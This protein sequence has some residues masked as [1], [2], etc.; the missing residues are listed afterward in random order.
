M[1]KC[2]ISIFCL[3]I[4]QCCAREAK[5]AFSFPLPIDQGWHSTICSYHTK[6]HNG[7][8]SLL[9][10]GSNSLLADESIRLDWKLYRSPPSEIKA[11]IIEEARALNKKVKIRTLLHEGEN[12]AFETI[13]ETN[14]ETRYTLYYLGLILPFNV[15]ITYMKENPEDIYSLREKYLSYFRQ[16]KNSASSKGL[17]FSEE[18]VFFEGKPLEFTSDESNYTIPGESIIVSMPRSWNVDRIKGRESKLY[19]KDKC[20]LEGHSETLLFKL[21]GE[22]ENTKFQKSTTLWG[23]DGKIIKYEIK[24]IDK[25]LSQLTAEI[26]GIRSP[27]IF[28]FCGKKEDIEKEITMIERTLQHF[29]GAWAA[30]SLR[31]DTQ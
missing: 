28:D 17:S 25:S 12:I 3:F 27:Y 22:S 29:S 30:S 2:L 10:K 14:G 24:D 18:G 15:A 19:K 6:S 1:R 20:L 4:S 5:E 23:L 9:P 13:T 11:S 8:I 16:L 7:Y 31:D 26:P 21:Y